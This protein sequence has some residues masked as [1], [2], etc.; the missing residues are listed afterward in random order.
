MTNNYFLVFDVGG[1]FIRGGAFNQHGDY[2]NSSFSFFPAKSQE[3]A[4]IILENL[5]NIICNQINRIFDENYVIKG[6]GFAF[7][8]PFDYENGISYIRDVKKYNSLYGLNIRQEIWE[9]LTK[10]KTFNRISKDVMF[11]FQNNVSMF[12]LGEWKER[13]Y[14]NQIKR[15]IFLTVGS[16]IGSAFL[17]NGM[18]IT[19][20]KDVPPN[21]WI[22]KLPF[23]N[24]I[25]D[26]YISHRGIMKI[27]QDMGIKNDMNWIT[28]KYKEGDYKAIDLFNRFGRYFG[29]VLTKVNEDFQSDI[30]VI[31]GE[32]SK[33]FPYYESGLM[34]CFKDKTTPIVLS[35][36]T[37]LS[38]FN[39]LFEY[40][41][42]H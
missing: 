12:A 25:I 14:N 23:H 37:E 36:Q 30:I 21:G 31:G 24:S 38:T 7:P 16:G 28:D 27:A 10:R 18:F 9:R 19:S 32:I 40:Y 42:Q 11:F 35:K 22:Y 39:G 3:S 29:E 33:L 5:T 4:D 6:I 20:R 17:E 1:Q 41:E 34:E 2:M 13:K 15:G 8:G 26:D